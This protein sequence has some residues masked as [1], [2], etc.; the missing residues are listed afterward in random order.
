MEITIPSKFQKMLDK[1][2]IGRHFENVIKVLKWVE[3]NPEQAEYVAEE[4][5]KLGQIG[6]D[7]FEKALFYSKTPQVALEHA[8][9]ISTEESNKRRQLSRFVHSTRKDG[10]RFEFNGSPCVVTFDQKIGGY[11]FKFTTGGIPV[12]LVFSSKYI[13]YILQDIKRGMLSSF[14][15]K[16]ILYRGA[17]YSPR[18]RT[19][20]L[21]ME[22]V[23]KNIRP[24]VMAVISAGRKR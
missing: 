21:L 6:R 16:Q 24:E 13:S 11:V 10:Y 1:L 23:R 9:K 22:A 14:G 12:Y 7:V 20:E 8:I 18:S 2:A 17:S 19:G 15:L 4:V 5:M 3:A